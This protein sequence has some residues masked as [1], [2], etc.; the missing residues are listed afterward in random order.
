LRIVADLAD[1]WNAV[2]L[3]V[4]EYARKLEILRLFC[5]SAGRKL[6]TIERSYYGSC[7]V[8]SNENEFRESFNRYYGQYR[9]AEEPMET[10]LQRMRSTRPLIGTAAEVAEK[11]KS[12]QEL[13]VSYFILYFPDKDGLS[14]LKRFADLVMPRFTSAS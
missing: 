14:L 12:F 11:M 7:V 13:G 6:N 8:G 3:S 5:E 4:D 9:K 10:F 1:G 2:G